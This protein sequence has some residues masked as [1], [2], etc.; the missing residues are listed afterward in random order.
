MSLIGL[1]TPLSQRS[2]PLP[3]SSFAC[4]SFRFVCNFRSFAAFRLLSALLCQCVAAAFCSTRCLCS[5]HK[6]FFVS[7][8]C[9]CCPCPLCAPRNAFEGFRLAYWLF[10]PAFG[11]YN[12]NLLAPLCSLFDCLQWILLAGFPATPAK[13]SSCLADFE[14][15]SLHLTLLTFRVV[16]VVSPVPCPLVS[17]RLVNASFGCSGPGIGYWLLFS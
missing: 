16:P 5:L 9:Q 17:W 12:F 15:Y 13:R 2:K 6:L 8:A 14:G 1:V 3:P 11:R 4:I 7:L 10:S